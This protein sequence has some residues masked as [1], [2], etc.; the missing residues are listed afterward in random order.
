VSNLP[1]GAAGT[2]VD[3]RFKVAAVVI[4]LSAVYLL[5]QHTSLAPFSHA[6]DDFVGGLAIGLTI[7]SALAWFGGRR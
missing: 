3:L 1:S 5:F 6:A 7:G 2:S 4:V